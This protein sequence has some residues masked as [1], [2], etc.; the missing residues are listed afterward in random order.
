MSD[1]D[2]FRKH[3]GNAF[4]GT[5]EDVQDHEKEALSSEST[6]IVEVL[7]KYEYFFAKKHPD[8]VEPVAGCDS[9]NFDV[10][11]E[12][13]IEG[14]GELSKCMFHV[15]KCGKQGVEL[16][17]ILPELNRSMYRLVYT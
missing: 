17:M 8:E 11:D 12:H 14:Y 16:R 13:E 7:K 6:S 15:R 1:D 3:V 5:N 2:K 10:T 4:T 9:E